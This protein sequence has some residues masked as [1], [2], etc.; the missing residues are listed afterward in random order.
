MG[1][2]PSLHHRSEQANSLQHRCEQM[3]AVLVNAGRVV[4]AL[5]TDRDGQLQAR[6]W[7]LPAAADRPWL[8]AMLPA[9]DLASQRLQADA[10]AAAVD[11]C[12]RQLLLRGASSGSRPSQR[13][14]SLP[15]A[16][17][18]R[19]RLARIACSPA[20][21]FPQQPPLL[22]PPLMLQQ[23]PQGAAASGGK[24]GG[25]QVRSKRA[26]GRRVERLK[27][28]R[29]GGQRG[30][31]LVQIHACSRPIPCPPIRRSGRCN[32]WGRWSYLERRRIGRS[33]WRRC[34]SSWW[35]RN[36]GG[37]QELQVHHSAQRA[38]KT[39]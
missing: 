33:A 10:L 11:R 25:Q 9:D 4:P 21:L 32:D 23:G 20:P 35:W 16:W 8:E 19:P 2:D 34:I 39:G 14:S 26:L 17:L 7:P 29:P 5:E 12:V 1:F 6:W 28:C 27:R 38:V 30:S 15:E 3:A 31:G 18:T 36:E 37:R 13:S 24:A 22:L